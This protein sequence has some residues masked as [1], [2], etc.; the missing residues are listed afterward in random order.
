MRRETIGV[1]LLLLGLIL[2][3]IAFLA[4]QMNVAI[5][6]LIVLIYWI[7]VILLIVYG[8]YLIFKR[9]KSKGETNVP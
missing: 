2:V 4:D 1:L 6:D 8:L 3:I 7:I 5:S 9:K